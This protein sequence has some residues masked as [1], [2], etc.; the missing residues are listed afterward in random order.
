[1]AMRTGSA[2]TSP[3]ARLPPPSAG[4]GQEKASKLSSS[5]FYLDRTIFSVCVCNI[6]TI[7]FTWP[8][9][10]NPVE[11]WGIRLISNDDISKQFMKPYGSLLGNDGMTINRIHS[12]KELH[13]VV[14]VHSSN[15]VGQ[16][17]LTL[18]E[19][20]PFKCTFVILG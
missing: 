11:H 4:F 7:M 20:Y 8:S 1:M 2:I 15:P 18:A 9:D 19:E 6:M 16:N 14:C 13:D 3:H 10:R 5:S 17:G 12:M